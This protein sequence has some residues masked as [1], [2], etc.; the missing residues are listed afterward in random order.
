MAFSISLF[1]H[2][3]LHNRKKKKNTDVFSIAS[4]II[5]IN[6]EPMNPWLRLGDFCPLQPQWKA[7]IFLQ[8]HN[9]SE[10]EFRSIS[11]RKKTTHVLLI[12]SSVSQVGLK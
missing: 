5:L 2:M 9:F 1:F 11:P 12:K 3:I 4:I 8:N 10:K 7:V 6:L